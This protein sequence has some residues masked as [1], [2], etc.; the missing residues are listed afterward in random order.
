MLDPEHTPHRI[1]ILGAGT[2]GTTLGALLAEKGM[3]VTVWS[4]SEEEAHQLQ[5]ERRHPNLP[6][7]EFPEALTFTP[8]LG[9]TLAG[10]EAVT[11]VVPSHAVRETCKR[12][13]GANLTLPRAPFVIATKGIEEDTLCLM[14]EVVTQELGDVPIAVLSGPSHAEEVSK[15]IPTAVVSASEDAALA[16]CVQHL[17]LTDRFRVYTQSDVVGVELAGA[18]KNVI[19]IAAG[20][21][22]GLRLGDNTLAALI[23]RG[24]AEIARLG[25]RLGAK[26]ET[27]LGLAG[28]GDLIVTATSLHS[29]NGRFGRLMAKPGMTVDQALAEIG[30]VVEGLTTAPVLRDLSRR[31]GIELPITEAVCEVLDGASLGQLIAGLMERRPTGEYEASGS[32]SPHAET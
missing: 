24:L 21:C 25:K 2:W 32:L 16:Q 19:A 4:H 15:R 26:T 8:S 27:F 23:T 31:V 30:M 20:V 7:L 9:E 29:R 14:S 17:F 22:A 6:E 5:A 3:G 28:I 10:A 18:L 13:A 11:L 12:I 1:A